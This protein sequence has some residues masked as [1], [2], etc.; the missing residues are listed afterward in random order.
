MENLTIIK[1][2]VS[3]KTNSCDKVASCFR[4]TILNEEEKP[5]IEGFSSEVEAQKGIERLTSGNFYHL[6]EI[7]KLNLVDYFGINY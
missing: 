7:L 3:K 5:L 6:Q 1:Q 4:Y 2:R